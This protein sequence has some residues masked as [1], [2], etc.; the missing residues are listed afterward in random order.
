MREWKIRAALG[1]LEEKLTSRHLGVG[2]LNVESYELP[3]T[4]N[5]GMLH[6]LQ[7]LVNVLFEVGHCVCGLVNIKRFRPRNSALNEKWASDLLMMMSSLSRP[8]SM[9]AVGSGSGAS[10]M[11]LFAKP[12]ILS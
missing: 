8:S 1:S 2:M 6:R 5:L 7:E 9:N 10:P 3:K 12:S 4:T 11:Y